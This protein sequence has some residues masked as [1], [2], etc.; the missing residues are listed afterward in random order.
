MARVLIAIPTFETV[1]PDTFKALWDMDKGGNE[2]AFEFVRGYDCATARNRIAKM[3]LDGGYDY[4]LMVD[5]DVTP[6]NDA[7]VNLLSHGVECVSGFYLHRN[8]DNKPSGNTCVCKLTDEKGVPYFDYPLESEYTKDE[9]AKRRSEGQNLIEIHGGG[10]GCVLVRADV[11]R[12]LRYPWFDWVNYADDN[13]SML[14]EDL[15]FCEKMRKRGIKR[16]VDARVACGHL[17]RRI[18]GAM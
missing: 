9:L 12:R 13:R 1:T 2:T 3:T 14:S 15:Y 8:A 5:N 11:F 16:H 10:M 6:P 4:C 7:L 17:F 18:E